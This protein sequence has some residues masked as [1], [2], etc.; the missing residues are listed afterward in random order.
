[1][2]YFSAPYKCC[3]P[4][5]YVHFIENLV[6]VVDGKRFSRIVANLVPFDPI[7]NNLFA[8]SP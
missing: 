2:S 3:A 7:G 8:G 5:S 1:M 6:G 4:L